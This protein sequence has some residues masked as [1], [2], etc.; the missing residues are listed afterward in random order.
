M[1]AKKT[2]HLVYETSTCSL[3][4][5]PILVRNAQVRTLASVKV[6]LLVASIECI[7]GYSIQGGQCVATSNFILLEQSFLENTFTDITGWTLSGNKGGAKVSVCAGKSMVGG[8]DIFGA[9]A[10]A[11]RTF[12]LPPHLRLKI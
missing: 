2:N 8:F 11:E 4:N 12:N 1:R 5:V 7:A 10:V 9:K 3:Q 6:T